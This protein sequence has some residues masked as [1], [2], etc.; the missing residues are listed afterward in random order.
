MLLVGVANHSPRV[1]GR[2]ICATK[3]IASSLDASDTL[4]YIRITI[5]CIENCYICNIR[6]LLTVGNIILIDETSHMNFW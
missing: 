5:N 2:R 1:D 6:R 3:G 4:E